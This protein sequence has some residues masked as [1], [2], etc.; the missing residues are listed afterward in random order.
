MATNIDLSD[1]RAYDWLRLRP[2]LHAIKTRRYNRVNAEFLRRS[3]RVGD[4]EAI[5]HKIAGRRVLVTIAFQDPE[6]LELQIELVRRFVV[7]DVHLIVD[8]SSRG[9]A[10]EANAAIAARFDTPY[11][12]LPENPWNGVHGSRSHGAAMTWAW[13]KVLRPAAPRAFG[14]LDDDLFPIQAVDPFAPLAE[15]PFH[16]SV[17]TAGERWFLWAGYCFYRFDAVRDLDLDF[18]QD[19][20]RKLDTGGANWALLYRHAEPSSFPRDPVEHRPI[21]PGVPQSDAQIQIRGAW[22]HESNWDTRPDL[23]PVK[24]KAVVRLLT[25]I[26][27]AEAT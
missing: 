10:A 27:A 3:P 25:D 17:R 6:I 1:Y 7:H 12:R 13:N 19:W 14:F 24:R 8:N 26:L 2:V 20:F 4:V 22:L 15:V 18:G 21:L 16:G 5:R 9:E 23:L 11:V